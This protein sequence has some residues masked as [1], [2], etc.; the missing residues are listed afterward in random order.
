MPLGTANAAAVDATHAAA[1]VTAVGTT[2][3]AT[4]DATL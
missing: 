2:L 4:V 3:C 1:V